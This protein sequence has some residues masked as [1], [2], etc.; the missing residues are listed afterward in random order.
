MNPIMARQDLAVLAPPKD[1]EHGHDEDE[2]HGRSDVVD[3]AARTSILA[4]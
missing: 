3:H 2:Q 1:D 4:A